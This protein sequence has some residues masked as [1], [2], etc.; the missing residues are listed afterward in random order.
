MYKKLAHLLGVPAISNR[1]ILIVFKGNML[2]Q[3][4]GDILHNVPLDRETTNPLVLLPVLDI[5]VEINRPSHLSNTHKLTAGID[6]N[7]I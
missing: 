6:L 7:K 3:T 5:L 2:Q 1:F 4:V